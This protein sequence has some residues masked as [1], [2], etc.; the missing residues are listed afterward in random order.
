MNASRY[1]TPKCRLNSQQMQR[2]SLLNRYSQTLYLIKS[3]L[4]R[5][6]KC[7][8]QYYDFEFYF[9]GASYGVTYNVNKL[10]NNKNNCTII[11]Q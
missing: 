10:Y 2:W 3:Q 9:D 8:K 6:D 1:K 5:F 7:T 4:L 11:V